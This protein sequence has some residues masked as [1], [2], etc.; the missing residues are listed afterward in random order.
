M[1][2]IHDSR[3]SITPHVGKNILDIIDGR[4][5]RLDERML[6]AAQLLRDEARR[7]AAIRPEFLRL[8]LRVDRAIARQG[9]LFSTSHVWRRQT[10]TGPRRAPRRARRARCPVRVVGDRD[11]PAPPPRGR[12][13]APTP[14]AA[15]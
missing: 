3:R 13:S 15:S 9:Q 7:L 8:Y 4:A 10:R 12:R 2:K 11:G 5:G 1:E 6:Q 14:G